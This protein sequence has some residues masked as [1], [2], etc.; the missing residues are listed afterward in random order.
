MI[1]HTYNIFNLKEGFASVYNEHHR[2]EKL[3]KRN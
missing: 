3:F 1:S 2:N